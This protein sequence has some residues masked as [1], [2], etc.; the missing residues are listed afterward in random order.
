MEKTTI[1]GTQNRLGFKYSIFGEYEEIGKYLIFREYAESIL[2]HMENTPKAVFALMPR[3][4]TE[5]ISQN[6]QPK[7]KIF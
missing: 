6:F 2:A 5:A 3:E 4:K 7:S 1:R